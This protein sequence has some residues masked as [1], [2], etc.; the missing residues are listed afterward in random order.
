MPAQA[1][2]VTNTKGIVVIAEDLE[3]LKRLLDA[4]ALTAEEFDRAKQQVL[5]NTSGHRPGEIYGIRISLW[6]ALMHLSQ[7]LWWTGAG[8]IAPIVL[9]ILGREQSTEIDKHGKVIINWMLSA[10]IFGAVFYLLTFLFVGWLLLPI[11]G[12]LTLV[13]PILGT[14]KALNKQV[15]EYPLSFEFLKL[16][17]DQ[18]ES[19][20]F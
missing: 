14:I 10:M 12:L 3:R 16:D 2:P 15:W 4:G 8:I 18:L 5:N 17:S 19:S 1:V 9:W 11:H 13:F 6:C 7:L 20:H